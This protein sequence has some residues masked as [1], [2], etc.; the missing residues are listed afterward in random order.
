MAKKIIIVLVVL[1]VVMGAYFVDRKLNKNNTAYFGEN[2]LTNTPDEIHPFG[3]TSL[4]KQEAEV[5]KKVGDTIVRTSVS[6]N[7]IE[8]SEGK[9][10][11][12]K[13][14]GS[15]QESSFTPFIRLRLPQ[16]WATTCKVELCPK[17]S[18]DCPRD[19]VD[20]PPKDLGSWTDK[21]YSP[22]LYDLIYK[23]LEFAQS[24]NL[25]NYNTNKIIVGNEI[26]SS[27][28]WLGTTDDYLKTR[29]TIYKAAEDINKKYGSQYQIV[30]NGLASAVWE[31]AIIRE[32]YCNGQK[33]YA[34]DFAER[35]FR[36]ETNI[37]KIDE[38]VQKTNCSKNYESEDLINR[39]FKVDPNLG[40]P[41][42]D[43]MSYHFYEPWDVQEEVI[44]WI[45]SK[46][47]KQGYEKPILNTEGGFVDR[48]RISYGQFLELKNEVANDIPKIHVVA[49]ANGVQSW[50][51]LP[52]IEE[53]GETTGYHLKGLETDNRT[54]LPA[55]YSYKT[56]TSKLD[57]FKTAE[58][59]TGLSTK[60]AY[61]F[62][63]KNKNPVYVLWDIKDTVVDFSAISSGQVK[64][65]K[66]DGTTQNLSS[67][68]V[69]IG[70]SPIYVEL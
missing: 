4:S 13:F 12:D 27:Q 38:E 10:N 66:V 40:K 51:W 44:S 23:T 21:G 7:Q 49:F 15:T 39:S 56:L 5:A 61:K 54:I 67:S 45:K 46:M 33:D 22:L 57:G 31:Y 28:F 43:F 47:E 34:K 64:I 65:T 48:N 14:K 41:S 55:Y 30:D 25:K 18:K 53:S 42:F 59:I 35:A 29:T 26:N 62:S 63:F 58:K 17:N 60:Y 32:S 69:S 68:N 20:C 2:A 8:P 9:F 36:R 50:L 1:T 3:F 52:L 70:V 6:W 11:F 24:K 19:L 37:A 16:G